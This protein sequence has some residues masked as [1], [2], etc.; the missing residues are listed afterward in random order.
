MEIECASST[1]HP[2]RILLMISSLSPTLCSGAVLD[3]A[4]TSVLLSTTSF[5]SGT[6]SAS[7]GDIV[8]KFV[9]PATSPETTNLQCILNIH[10]NVWETSGN[11]SHSCGEKLEWIIEKLVCDFTIWLQYRRKCPEQSRTNNLWHPIAYFSIS[12]FLLQ[13]HAP[14]HWLV[15]VKDFLAKN[16]VTT[17]EL[18]P[19]SPDLAPA[20]FYLSPQLKSSLKRTVLLW[21]YEHN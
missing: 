18:P 19:Y 4:A 6:I 20:D 17:L 7:T 2:L 9:L 12:W 1:V 8:F 14:A 21:G 5:W 11:N 16:N 15:L 13:I 10:R 3:W